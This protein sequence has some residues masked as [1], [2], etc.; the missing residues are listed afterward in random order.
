MRI[1]GIGTHKK[2]KKKLLLGV[3]DPSL[4]FLKIKKYFYYLLFLTEGGLGGC[5][6]CVFKQQFSVF[7]QHFFT[8]TYFHKY[9]QTTIFSF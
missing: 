3:L 7:K 9:F 5:L 6:V 2:E 8:H 4:I 1:M